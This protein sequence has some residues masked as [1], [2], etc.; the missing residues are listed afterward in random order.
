M[1]CLAL[2]S[3]ASLVPLVLVVLAVT[4]D[5]FFCRTL[6]FLA[7]VAFLAFDIGMLAADQTEV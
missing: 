2:G 3:I 6:V 7:G 1:T 4:P 5:A